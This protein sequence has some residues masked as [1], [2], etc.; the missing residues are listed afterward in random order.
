LA[1]PVNGIDCVIPL[2]AFEL[3]VSASAKDAALEGEK[4]TVTLQLLPGE[5]VAPQVFDCEKAF[6]PVPIE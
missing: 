3:I 4:V 2:T 5:I 6:V 1:L